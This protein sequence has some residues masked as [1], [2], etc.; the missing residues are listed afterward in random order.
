MKGTEFNENDYR[1]IADEWKGLAT[2]ARERCRDAEEFVVVLKA[3]SLP[4]KHIRTC[5]AARE[6][7]IYSIR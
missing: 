7:H 6:S 5:A 2:M 3:L 1:L 4:M